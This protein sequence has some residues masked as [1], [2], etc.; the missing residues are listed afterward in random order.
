MAQTNCIKLDLG[1]TPM[2]Q[3]DLDPTE[4]PY[5][6]FIKIEFIRSRSWTCDIRSA[7]KCLHHL[8][9]TDLYPSTVNKVIATIYT[10]L[11]KKK[12]GMDPT[13]SDRDYQFDVT[14]PIRV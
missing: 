11:I 14:E 7:Y 10:Q 5:I 1:M 8:I 6:S 12:L 4:N 2:D 13:G 3:V 9:S